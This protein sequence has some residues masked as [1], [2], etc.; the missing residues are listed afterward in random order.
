MLPTWAELLS[1]KLPSVVLNDLLSTLKGRSPPFPVDDWNE[2]AVPLVILDAVSRV[3]SRAYASATAIA[4]GGFLRLASDDWLPL[5][6]QNK[7]QVTRNAAQFTTGIV[8]FRC[9]ANAGPYTLE[10]GLA[11]STVTGLGYTT[12][13]VAGLTLAAGATLQVPVKATSPGAAWNI[14]AGQTLR[15]NTTKPGV[16]VTNP[17][18]IDVNN[19]GQPDTW[20]SSYGSDI[21]SLKELAD[22][23]AARM[24]RLSRLQNVPEDG[25]V[26]AAKDA[27]AVVKKV[28]V[29]SNYYQGFAAPGAVTLFLAGDSGPVAPAVVKAVY[30]A[31][32]PYRCP[33]GDLYVDSCVPF[34]LGLDGVVEMDPSLNI[35]AVRANV[36]ANL[37][38]YQKEADPG[39]LIYGAEII[40]RVMDTDGVINFR[41]KNLA[42]KRLAA[43]EVV[44]F[45]STRLVYQALRKGA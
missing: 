31:L 2:G 35:P 21:E 5:L 34:N 11:L 26:S 39:G 43:N 9:S 7:Y 28:V 29:F 16:T 44:V 10:P 37:V 25:Y 30:D 20:I 42:D 19:D 8:T 45:D 6:A 17:P 38:A 27:S 32:Y 18:V 15:L 23:C 1:G 24:G 13:N 33:L 36:A 4:R 22:R 14:A 12:T 41:P 3:F 40:Q